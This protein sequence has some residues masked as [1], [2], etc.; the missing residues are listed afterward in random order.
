MPTLDEAIRF[1]RSNPLVA[2]E[3]VIEALDIG[4][5]DRAE[6]S[7]GRLREL[8]KASGGAVDKKSRAWVEIDTLPAVLRKIIDA[9]KQIEKRA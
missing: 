3:T 1:I 2:W 8:W 6:V 4:S 5:E 9:V 7:G